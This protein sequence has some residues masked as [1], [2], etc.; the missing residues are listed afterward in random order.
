M[1]SGL[2]IAYWSRTLKS[3]EWN[4]S[5]TERKVLGAKEALVK[6]QP[7]VEGEKII[8]IMDHTALQWA[9]VYKT[10]N[11]RLAAWGAV[12]AVYPGLHIVH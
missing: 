6:F 2:Y 10:A 11:R 5:A 12:F 3:A 4:Y 1:W 9:R 8:L 7:F